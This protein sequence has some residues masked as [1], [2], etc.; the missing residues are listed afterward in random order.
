[1]Q[2]ALASRFGAGAPSLY[3]NT[4][5][6]DDQIRS[7]APSIFAEAPHDSRSERYSYIPT[8]AVLEKLRGNGFQPFM[9][10]QTRVRSEDRR[11][12]T[13][14]ML[15]LRHASQTADKEAYEVILLNS[16]DGTSSYQM[17]AGMFRLCPAVHSLNYVRRRTMSR[18]HF[19]QLSKQGMQWT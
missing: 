9:V 13:K 5:L 6:S 19:N 18:D 17:L 10:G 11:E 14:H 12:F 7:V 4:P 15:R 8:S 16:H 1:M 3:S 2:Q